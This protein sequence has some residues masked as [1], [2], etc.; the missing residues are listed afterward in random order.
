METDPALI[1]ASPVLRLMID[2]TV[3]D[4][5]LIFLSPDIVRTVDANLAAH[6]ER[7]EP[8][9]N[10]AAQERVELIFYVERAATCGSEPVSSEY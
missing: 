6:T 5:W 1:Q 3:R 2:V 7:F 9:S 8:R 10:I 4:W